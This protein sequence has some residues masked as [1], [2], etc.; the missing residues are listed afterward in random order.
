[1]AD[2][3]ELERALAADWTREQ[4]AVYGDYLQSLAD[5]RGELIA[6]DLAGR[7]EER[8]ARKRELVVEWL[9]EDLA[10]IVLHVGAVD[11]AFIALGQRAPMMA[12]FAAFELLAHPAGQYLRALAVDDTRMIDV[13]ELLE[14]RARPW[15]AKLRV[16]SPK[17]DHEALLLQRVCL[18]D[19]SLPLLREVE[20]VGPAGDGVR[21]PSF[22]SYVRVSRQTS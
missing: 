19:R 20:L 4:L 6:I 1:M 13:Y 14:R 16:R 7:S 18:A 5:P 22:P 2:L 10:T 9:G 11:H 3:A 21:E 12:A 17:D 8:A 15:L